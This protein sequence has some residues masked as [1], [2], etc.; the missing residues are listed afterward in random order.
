MGY[1]WGLGRVK[2]LFWGHPHVVEHF[3]FSMFPLVL[4]FDFDLILGS[5]LLFGAVL[6]YF[7]V[8]FQNCFGV[9]SYRLMSFVF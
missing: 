2:K 6:G 4:T 5:F 7:G 9:S 3:S 1:F 8:G